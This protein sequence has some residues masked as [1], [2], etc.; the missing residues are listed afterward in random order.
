[1]RFRRDLSRLI[2]AAAQERSATIRV[3]LGGVVAFGLC[4]ISYMVVIYSALLSRYGKDIIQPRIDSLIKG[5]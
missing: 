4:M 5:A 2:L 1:M 3:H